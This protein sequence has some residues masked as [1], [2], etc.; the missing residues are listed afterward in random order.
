M[1]LMYLKGN[2]LKQICDTQNPKWFPFTGLLT[3]T[4]GIIYL[5]RPLLSLL[6]LSLFSPHS[7]SAGESSGNRK[8]HTFCSCRWWVPLKWSKF[9]RVLGSTHCP[10]WSVL[11]FSSQSSLSLS[12]WF[13]QNFWIKCHFILSHF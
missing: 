6:F 1:S 7:I 11:F 3:S 8:R 12:Q 5:K 9:Q 4:S 13:S 10:L 2:Y